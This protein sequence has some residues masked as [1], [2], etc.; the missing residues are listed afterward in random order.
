MGRNEINGYS[1]G[2]SETKKKYRKKQM[3]ELIL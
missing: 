2:I 1:G 3:Y